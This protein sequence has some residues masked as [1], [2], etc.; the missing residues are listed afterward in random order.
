MKKL[1]NTFKLTGK[2]KQYTN[3]TLYLG[4]EDFHGLHA[5]SL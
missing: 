5:S 3:E 4:V 1:T 2:N